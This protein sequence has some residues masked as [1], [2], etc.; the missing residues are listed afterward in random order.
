MTNNNDN[1]TSQEDASHIEL[2]SFNQDSNIGL[3]AFATDKFCLVGSEIDDRYVEIIERTLK[4]PVHKITIAG[5]SLIGV[6]VSGN[7]DCILI[8]EITFGFE[9]KD[10]ENLGINYKIIE[11]NVTALGNS[12]AINKNGA[13][14]SKEFSEET[15]EQIKAALN[16]PV[17]EGKIADLEIV[18]SCVALND[19]GG[20]IHRDAEEFEIKLLEKLFGVEFREGTINMG[21]PYIKSGVIT[22]NKGVLIGSNSGGP[23]ANNVD[24]GLGF[25]K[26]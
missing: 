26:I 12:I 15:K 17:K 3:Y 19:Q 22:N 24:I 13:Y 20:I 10:L 21:S 5:T 14:L 18:G 7:E 25:L 9:K 16:I 1:Q 4:V 23:E 11:S 8:P 6:F 2:I